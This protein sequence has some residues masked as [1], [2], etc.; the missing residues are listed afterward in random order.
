MSLSYSQIFRHSTQAVLYSEIFYSELLSFALLHLSSF[1]FNRFFRNT[2][3]TH[4]PHRSYHQLFFKSFPRGANSQEQ[5]LRLLYTTAGSLIRW[6]KTLKLN[7]IY[8]V[9]LDN[10]MQQNY[11]RKQLEIKKLN[12]HKK[13]PGGEM[14]ENDLHIAHCFVAESFF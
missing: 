3:L 1:H 13:A 8:E 11:K 10:I 4:L 12:E 14:E 7:K 2:S 6:S 9:S 5:N